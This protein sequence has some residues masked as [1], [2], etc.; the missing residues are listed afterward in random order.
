[1]QEG[2]MDEGNDSRAQLIDDREA[3][4]CIT[5]QQE[6]ERG[7]LYAAPVHTSANPGEDIVLEAVKPD[8]YLQMR[9]TSRYWRAPACH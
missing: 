6:T 2:R 8:G 9:I 3:I 1:G 5:R 4:E 7:N